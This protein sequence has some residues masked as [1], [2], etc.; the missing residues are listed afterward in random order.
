MSGRGSETEPG[1]IPDSNAW[2]PGEDKSLSL[3]ERLKSSDRAE[4]VNSGSGTLRESTG[5]RA[6]DKHAK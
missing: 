6:P 1:K 5:S 3:S 2:L 4:R